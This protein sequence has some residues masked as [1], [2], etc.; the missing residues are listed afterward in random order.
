MKPQRYEEKNRLIREAFECLKA[1]H[2]E[3]LIK[4][5]QFSWSNW[6]FGLER[7]EDSC[8]RLE[9]AGIR[10]IELHGNHYGPD[11]GYRPQETK[12]ILSDH[13]ITA[14]GVCGMFSA[15]NDLS[16]IHHVRR[17]AAIDYIRRELDF[18]AEIGGRYLL[19]CPG[20]V[21]RPEKYDESELDRSLDSLSRVADRF[22]SLDIRAAI[23]PIRSAETSLI[24]TFAQAKDYIT[25]LNHPGVQHI[26]GD[27]YH[28]L[29][30]ET[31]IAT[32]I[33]EAGP[34]LTNLHMADTN[35]QGL[36]EGMMDLDN[37]IMALYLIGYN[38]DSC[39]VTPEPL[40]PGGDPYP[41]QNART[42][43]AILD[44]LVLGSVK[45]F[46]ERESFLLEE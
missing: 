14:A 2:P 33:W 22:V 43:P 15:D 38:N 20:A 36:G 7:L 46:R 35:R 16:S 29:V 4:R 42:E 34:M 11:L 39:F 6:G 30:E 9:K 41:A 3:K 45:Y 18:T 25:R 26:N 8:Q 17:Q 44:Y 27:I 24:H 32:T 31:H 10:F 28:M 37:I 40:G 21:G 13:G 1:L 23:E 5:L 12:R 19:V